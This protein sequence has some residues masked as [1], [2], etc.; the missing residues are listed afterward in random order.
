M[1]TEDVVVKRRRE[2][3]NLVPELVPVSAHVTAPKGTE[4]GPKPR[5]SPRIDLS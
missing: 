5:F 1:L 2:V 3:G 4:A